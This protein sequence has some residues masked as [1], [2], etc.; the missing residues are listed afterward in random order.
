MVTKSAATVLC[1]FCYVALSSCDSLRQDRAGNHYPGYPFGGP[2]HDQAFVF[3]HGIYGDA[4]STWQNKKGERF[5]DFMKSDEVYKNSDFYVYGFP[6]E[7]FAPSF[8]I[9]DVVKNMRNRLLH[10]KVL[11][12]KTIIFVA[13]SMGGLIVQRYLLAYREDAKKVP[14]I[15]LYSTPSEGSQLANVGKLFSPNEGLKTM[16]NGDSNAYLEN[17][18]N[19]WRQAKDDRLLETRVH[20]AFEKRQTSGLAVV[21]RLSATR[22]CEGTQQPVD[23]DHIGIVK[24]DNPQDDAYVALR[25]AFG[26]FKTPHGRQLVPYAPEPHDTNDVGLVDSKCPHYQAVF[27]DGRCKILNLEK[28]IFHFKSGRVNYE[29][30]PGAIKCPII[31]FLSQVTAEGTCEI[32][33][34]MVPLYHRGSL[35]YYRPYVDAQ[36]IEWKKDGIDLNGDDYRDFSAGLTQCESECM[37]DQNCKAFAW[38]RNGGHCWLK[39]GVPAET[40]HEGI[41]SGRK[42]NSPACST[43]QKHESKPPIM[44]AQNST[45]H[46][47][48]LGQES[49]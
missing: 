34:P 11:E 28:P 26:S 23:K 31:A 27:E 38:Q 14:L 13:H 7:I 8:T 45:N 5:F 1:L 25:N 21:T 22:L 20:C 32:Q 36:P 44:R 6:S 30:Q 3:V 33:S 29:W 10:D 49:R 19:E 17:L 46:I 12:H 2:S 16:L 41:V 9:D 18:E 47:S 15:F 37:Y 40:P 39:D 24:I 42:V 43:A 35:L 4:Y 48:V